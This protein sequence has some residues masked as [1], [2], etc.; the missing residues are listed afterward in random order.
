MLGR[1]EPSSA[2]A[3]A[4]AQVTGKG[5][6]VHL[7]RLIPSGRLTQAQPQ[8]RSVLALCRCKRPNR[9]R[10]LAR[11]TFA[12]AVT[13]AILALLALVRGA[14]AETAVDRGHY[15][16]NTVAACGRCHTPRLPGGIPDPARELAGGFT[17]DDPA[18]GHIVGPN[19]TPDNETGLGKWRRKRSSRPCATARAQTVR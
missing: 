12:A 1:R 17:F 5:V 14:A 7:L 15:L 2:T 3:D 19:L 8:G 13:L 11:R 9:R 18:I 10:F 4:A 16:V 6:F